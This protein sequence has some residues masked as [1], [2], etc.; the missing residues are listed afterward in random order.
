MT[1]FQSPW[2]T[3]N[4]RP[5]YLDPETEATWSKTDIVIES[6]NGLVDPGACGK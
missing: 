4:L 1:A 5:E 3:P 6:C 2:Q